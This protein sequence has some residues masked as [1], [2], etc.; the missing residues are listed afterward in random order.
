MAHPALH[1]LILLLLSIGVRIRLLN[2]PSLWFD[3]AWA[4]VVWKADSLLQAMSLSATAPA[5]GA[6]IRTWLSW[7]GFSTLS[8]QMPAFVI[9]V[10]LPPA[11]YLI[12]R[13]LGLSMWGAGV[14]GLSLAGAPAL[15]EASAHVKQYTLDAAVALG[16]LAI[17]WRVIDAPESGCRG[18]R[19]S[20]FDRRRWWTLAAASVLG[21]LLSTPAA[22]VAGAAFLAAGL[23]T[24]RRR[25]PLGPAMAPALV[26]A[27][28]VGLTW[29]LVVSRFVRPGIAA[30]F[31]QNLVELDAGV[32]GFAESIARPAARIATAGLPFGVW[33]I[34]IVAIVF[35]VLLW[36]ERDRFWLLA[37]PM[38][39]AFAAAL[40][41]VAPVGMKRTDCYLY[42]ALALALGLAIDKLAPRWRPAALAATIVAAAV[43]P[44]WRAHAP[45]V[46]H[47]APLVHTLE[48]AIAP[49]ESAIVLRSTSLSFGLYTT[50]P[51]ALEPV[52]HPAHPGFRAVVRRP[53]VFTLQ[54]SLRDPEAIRPQIV[55]A[56]Q[57]RDAVWV[58]ASG[59]DR[60]WLPLVGKML[61][62]LDFQ[63][64]ETYAEQKAELTRWRR[65]APEPPA[66][67]PR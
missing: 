47:V 15:V 55:S 59:T 51:I 37:L 44:F 40:V 23:A 19:R 1:A 28:S 34:P 32:P 41:R 29:L 8:A 10:L 31:D 24:W 56:V 38:A 60:L 3:D 53:D 27:L 35:A 66:G 50:W 36:R 7:A 63:R 62:E 67:T 33:S 52:P 43:T 21:M 2:P 22:I 42:P 49:G 4:A 17:A 11:A 18:P 65:K 58:I 30:A 54:G 39:G 61:G 26:A 48:R 6:I 46:D 12:A 5:F 16:V 13:R 20:L 25:L 45:V 9:G 14:A 64:A 57:G